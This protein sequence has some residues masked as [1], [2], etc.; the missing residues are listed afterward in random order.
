[1]TRLGAEPPA[2]AERG[3]DRGP[4]TATSATPGHHDPGSSPDKP[5]V[6]AGGLRAGWSALVDVLDR[7]PGYHDLHPDVSLNFQLN[8][9]LAW[10]TAQAL[11]DVTRI[12]ARVRGYADVT[13]AFLALGDR[14][15]ADGRRLDAALCF[16]AA[17]FFLPPDDERRARAR[18]S[19]IDLIRGV[20]GIGPECITA[21]PYPGG[22]LPAYRFGMPDKG[23]VVL[24]G[25]FDSYLEE[26]LPVMLMIARRGYQVIGFEGPGQGGALEDHGLRLTPHWHR[27]VGAIL[28]HFGLDAVTLVGISLGG[29]LAIRA[30]AGEPRVARVIADDVLTDFL[31]ANLRQI[32]RAVRG[33]VRA[34]RAVHA[35]RLLD[36]V[37]L[38]RMRRDL[39]A[40]WGITHGMRVL[41]VATPHDYF[42]GIARFTTA[43]LSAAVRADVLLLAGAEDHYVPTRQLTDQIA[44]LTS[45]RSVTA[46]LFTRDEQA[47]NHC[48]VGNIALSVQVMLDW[49]AGLDERDRHI[50]SAADRR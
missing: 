40:H 42:T 39:L 50:P 3:D 21:V 8:R 45:A 25:G 22:V 29:G 13:T 28:D 47:H 44:T 49:L 6:A 32:P 16:R 18:R 26:F 20:Y 15:L 43:D 11:P 27:P 10:M 36:A 9:W 31:A 7:P 24:F 19:F 35:G 17:E 5:G 46:R 30:A 37:A 4:T 12:A 2:A 48:Q 33:T 14:L 23:T 1:M 41:G 34:L 38:R